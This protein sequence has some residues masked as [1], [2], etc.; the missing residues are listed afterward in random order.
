MTD[1]L[2]KAAVLGV[3]LSIGDFAE[4]VLGVSSG[5]DVLRIRSALS[6]LVK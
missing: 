5:D 1:Q 3:P 6:T 2:I 4:K